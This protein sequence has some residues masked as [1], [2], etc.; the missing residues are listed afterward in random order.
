MGD[1][2]ITF[3][4]DELKQLKPATNDWLLSMTRTERQW[5]I[6]LTDTVTT[7]ASLHR[8]VLVACGDK[9]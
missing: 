5:G 1:V 6:K 3:T 7:C 4:Q 9:D 2:T 8:K